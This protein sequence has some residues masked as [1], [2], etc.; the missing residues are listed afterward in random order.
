M[1]GLQV[2]QAASARLALLFVIGAALCSSFY[3]SL[4]G[5]NFAVD[6]RPQRRLRALLA[7]FGA[8]CIL[9]FPALACGSLFD[10]PVAV[11]I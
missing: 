2:K 4:L 7:I 1:L 6:Q 5:F 10:Q 8:A 9:F 11:F 3:Q